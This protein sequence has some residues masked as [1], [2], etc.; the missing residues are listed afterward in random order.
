M[1][2]YGMKVKEEGGVMEWVIDW[3]EGVGVEGGW[4]GELMGVV[5]D[6]GMRGRVMVWKGY[7]EGEYMGVGLIGEKMGEKVY[8]VIEKM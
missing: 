8:V 7:K 2:V 4:K 3:G 5:G 1:V 6:G